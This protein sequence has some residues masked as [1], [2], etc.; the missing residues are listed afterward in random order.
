MAEE[1]HEMQP[2]P[3]CGEDNLPQAT[4]CV[5]CGSDLDALFTFVGQ[6]DLPVEEQETDLPQILEALHG[7]DSL[8]NNI[9]PGEENPPEINEPEPQG[10]PG[11]D[12]PGWLEQVRERARAEDDASGE[13]VKG[14]TAMDEK[15]REDPRTQVDDEFNAWIARI[16]EHS[17]KTNAARTRRPE[18]GEADENGTPEWLRR[19]R[20]LQPKPEDEDTSRVKVGGIEDELAREW[21]QAELEELRRREL[22]GEFDIEPVLPILPLDLPVSLNSDDAPTNPAP[23]AEDKLA[24]ESQGIGEDSRAGSEA[25]DEQL[26]EPWIEHNIPDDDDED[27]LVG[28][29]A[30]LPEE[31]EPLTEIHQAALPAE[32]VEVI[33]ASEESISLEQIGGEQQEAFVPGEPLEEEISVVLVQPVEEDPALVDASSDPQT[34]PEDH[35]NEG[36]SEGTQTEQE[37]AQDFTESDEEGAYDE[38]ETGEDQAP[39]LLLLRDQARRAEVLR[40]LITEE[41][42]A[43]P[44][45]KNLKQRTG[46]V[47]RLV[48]ALLLLLGVTVTIFIAPG[49]QL[50]AAP[51]GAP[52]AAFGERLENLAAGDRVLVLLDYQAGSSAELEQLA[53]PVIAAIAASGVE[54][55]PLTTQ[56]AGLWLAGKLFAAADIVDPPTVAFLPGGQIGLAGM[57]SDTSLLPFD[58]GKQALPENLGI[59]EIDLILIITDSAAGARGWLEQVAPALPGGRIAAIISQKEAPVLLPYYDSGQLAG[60]L[61]NPAHANTSVTHFR[62]YQVGLLVM[63]V[64]LLLGVITKAEQD[65]TDQAEKGGQA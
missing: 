4:R 49:G 39:D 45:R 9:P 25:V 55:Q 60:M 2:C 64:A 13:L 43:R 8:L 17:R 22:A 29:P 1:T 27:L 38:I 59:R 34:I 18:P 21:T 37:P 14:A 58:P 31:E 42:R 16:R 56:P 57:I 41:G 10:V 15:L 5:H 65:A 6:Q 30:Q 3:V 44:R 51:T 26:S 23:E 36:V 52:A 61:A 19:I 35:F 24:P 47:G 11:R 33:E 7:Q 50:A 46:N 20:E 48:M 40:E 54:W 32:A 12:V 28:T 63:I 53:A 62:A